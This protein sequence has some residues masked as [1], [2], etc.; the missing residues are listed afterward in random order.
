MARCGRY[1]T[2]RSK[3]RASRAATGG[4]TRRSIAGSP[5]PWSRKPRGPQPV[6]SSRTITSRCCRRC[7]GRGYPD[8]IIVAF[9][10]IPWPNAAR[11]SRL[12]TGNA[13]L[14]GL[15]GSDIV[16]FQTPEH[17]RRFSTASRLLPDAAV[18]RAHG[19]V[20]PRH[21]TV[22]VRAYPISVEWPN[23]WAESAPPVEECRRR[24][25]AE[26][27]IEA[28][29]PMMISVDRLDYTKGI[30]ERLT[31]I[32]RLLARGNATVARPVF[33]QVAAPSRTRLERYRQLAG[34]VRAQVAAINERFGG[35][36]TS[37]SCCS[38]A[39]PSRRRSFVSTA[40]PTPA[41]STAWT[42]G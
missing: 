13:L 2:S 34:R 10:H 29:A 41:T 20:G 18:D 9:W 23:R 27:G 7:S 17:A 11:F 42:M 12:P 21:G 22:A 4:I 15:L 25:R 33:V 6:V 28:D 35:R 36:A 14:E 19:L 8:A 37:R 40:P 16:G 38:S 32:R 39:M 24:V 1:A 30:E 26:L 5:T 31:A 3:A